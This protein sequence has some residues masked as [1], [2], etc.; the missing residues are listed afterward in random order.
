MLKL[1]LNENLSW[2]IA[3]ALREYGYDVISS[4][5]SEMNQYDDEAQLSFAAQGGRTIVTNNFRDFVELHQKYEKEGKTHYDI[6][7]TTKCTLPIM[8]RRLRTL[9]ETVQKDQLI[10]QIRWLNEFE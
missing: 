3:K 2:R 1:Y 8:I 9:L 10:N 7:F 4:G 6:I 5:E